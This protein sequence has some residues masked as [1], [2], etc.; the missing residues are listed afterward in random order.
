MSASSGQRL[1][2]V[3]NLTKHFPVTAG[4]LV[5]REV[6]RVRAVDDVSFHVDRGETLGLVG[7][8]G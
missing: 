8:S 1:L 6:G 7:E 4:F 5:S 2:E 3:S